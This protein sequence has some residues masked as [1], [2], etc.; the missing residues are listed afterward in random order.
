M[1]QRTFLVTGATKGIGRALSQQLAGAGHYVVGIARGLDPD[2][3]GTL[4]SVDLSD[5][6]AS[7][8][9]FAVSP[10]ATPSTES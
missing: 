1:T 8:D 5:S 6:K 3:P 10:S 2:F 9:A 4:A 7:A